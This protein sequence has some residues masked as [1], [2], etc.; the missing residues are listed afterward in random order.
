[1]IDHACRFPPP[2][3]TEVTPNCFIVRDA[4]GQQLAYVYYESEPGRRSAAKLLSKDEARR[5]A[6]NI[7]KLPGAI[8]QALTRRARAGI[9]ATVVG[10][11]S[12]DRD[13]AY[14]VAPV[15]PTRSP[16]QSPK[17]GATLTRLFLLLRHSKAASGTQPAALPSSTSRVV[18]KHGILAGPS[19]LR[20]AARCDRSDRGSI[21][22]ACPGVGRQ[23]D[24]KTSPTIKLSYGAAL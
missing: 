11:I 7:A 23:S 13:R 17:A 18:P 3:S 16:P 20:R 10:S 4:D 9:L 6:A 15:A 21:V 12:C 8:T 19:R 5:I 24:S 1:V 2:W 14:P 22:W